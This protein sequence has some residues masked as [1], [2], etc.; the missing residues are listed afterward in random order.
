MAKRTTEIFAGNNTIAMGIIDAV[1]RHGLRIPHDI[2]LV[3][4]DDLPHAS[5]LFPFLTVA[6]Q[7]VYELGVNSAQL[8]LSRLAGGNALPARLSAYLP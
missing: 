6:S 5:H 2:A 8:L 3:S 7:P 1:G 4:F